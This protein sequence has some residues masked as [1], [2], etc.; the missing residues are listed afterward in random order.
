MEHNNKFLLL[1]GSW[2]NAFLGTLLWSE[3]ILSSLAYL[4]SIAGSITFIYKTH[5]NKKN[6]VQ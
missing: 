4:F 2:S 3:P 5:K 1:I 6:N